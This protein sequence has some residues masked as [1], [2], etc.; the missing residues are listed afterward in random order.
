MTTGLNGR[1]EVYM[2]IRDIFAA[3]RTTFSFEFSPPKTDAAAEL[4]FEHIR[5]LESLKPAFVSVTYG[6]R[7]HARTHA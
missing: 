3:H 2:H 1:K 7:Q 4:L 6:W 5:Q